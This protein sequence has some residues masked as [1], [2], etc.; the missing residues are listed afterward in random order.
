MTAPAGYTK[1]PTG[2]RCRC[3]QLWSEADGSYW[4]CGGFLTVAT[5]R[6]RPIADRVIEAMAEAC[7]DG[8]VP[9]AI[10]M[11]ES[12]WIRARAELDANG[13]TMC[14]TDTTGGRTMA[15]LPI[16]LRHGL[17]GPMVVSEEIRGEL[18]SSREFR[19][20]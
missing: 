2:T 16:L 13:C 11:G 9:S 4:C 10:V 1:L 8:I 14:G 12:Q 18:W 5:R 17:V 7:E 20:V 3:L 15:G 19:R 6:P